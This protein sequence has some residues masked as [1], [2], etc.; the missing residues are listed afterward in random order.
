MR[1]FWC[2]VSAILLLCTLFFS[3]FSYSKIDVAAADSKKTRAIAIVFDN[4]GS[5]YKKMNNDE[6]TRKAWCRAIYAMETFATMMNPQDT[7][8]IYPMHE[9]T[10]G[11]SSYTM[12]SPYVLTKAKAHTI[13]DIYSPNAAGTPIE[14][15]TAAHKGLAASTADEKWLIV[16][17]DGDAFRKGGKDLSASATLTELQKELSV[18]RS[19]EN[20]M[21]LGIGAKAVNPQ[22]VSGSYYYKCKIVTDSASVLTELSSMCNTIFGRDALSNVSSNVSF[23]VSMGKLILF[24]QGNGISN[25]KLGNLTPVS[26]DTLS[27]GT[28]GCGGN[29]KND[30]RIDDTLQGMMLTF[31][32]VDAGTYQLSYSG[33]ATSIDAYYEP[34]VNIYAVLK[35]AAGNIV[36]T[37]TNLNAGDYTIEYCLVDK[38]N[39]KTTSSLLGTPKFEVKYS[40]NGEEKTVTSDWE[41]TI[42]LTMEPNA[43]LDATFKVTYLKDYT[44]I[45]S[46]HE[47]GWPVGGFTFNPPPAGYLEV[48]LSGGA[49]SFNL[50][51]LP[52]DNKFRVEF[53]YE[54][55]ELTGAELDKVDATAKL[56][57]ENANAVLEKDEQGYFV[58]ITGAENLAETKITEYALTVTGVYTNDDG[59][60]TNMAVAKKK[61][62]IVDNSS[63]LTIDANATQKYYRIKDLENGEPIRV[64]LSFNG[65]PLTDDQLKAV[66]LEAVSNKKV[67]FTYE[68]IEGESAIAVRI[69]PNSEIQKGRHRITFNATGLNE[70][71]KTVNAQDKE[72]VQIRRVA[73]WIR[74]ALP[75]LLLLFIAAVLIFILTRKVLPKN[76]IMP[77]NTIS[78]TSDGDVVRVPTKAKY[79]KKK[80]LL[81]LPSPKDPATSSQVGL[82]L[83]LKAVS[84]RYVPSAQRQVEVVSITPTNKM[85]TTSFTFAGVIFNKDEDSGKFVQAGHTPEAP[86]SSYT[87]GTGTQV[88]VYGEIP[89]GRRRTTSLSFKSELQFK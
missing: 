44:L 42:P 82:K 70:I 27:Y 46:A 51:D 13:R 78:F 52:S 26:E 1:K 53:I 7:M 41:G 59:L 89:S 79:E 62:K 45:R 58:T 22:N 48:Q 32:N 29:Y 2:T 15:I 64:D 75:I 11:S 84:P 16:L 20:V 14:A 40:V 17:T 87:F 71:G 67:G 5:M 24:V 66:K 50:T 34:D 38:N 54:N 77:Y 85:N 37:D 43:V 49:D 68:I 55:R 73:R 12:N 19:S 8:M 60:S 28:K 86:F 10:I 72:T 74:I 30:W 6:E 31:E 4:S 80:G 3:T 65:T 69:D 18:C 88:Q 83:Q 76:I 39:A 61:F 33:N 63:Q 23:D 25:V 57:G 9:I 56:E 47:L 36:P 21:Y 35:D 81:T